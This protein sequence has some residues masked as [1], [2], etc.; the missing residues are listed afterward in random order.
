M[1]EKIAASCMILVSLIAG[2]VLIDS[3]FLHPINSA[4]SRPKLNGKHLDIAG[5]DWQK[6]QEHLVIAL[7]S[8]CRFCIADAPLYRQVT[9]D[10]LSNKLNIVVISSDD[11]D[12]LHRFLQQ[13]SIHADKILL[14]PLSS[15]GVTST[16]T[17][18]IVDSQGIVR[19]TFIGQLDQ[20]RQT[21]LRERLHLVGTQAN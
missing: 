9:N 8:H 20:S 17:L 16:P 1:L 3:H 10:S 19:A 7:S 5:I 21:A 14:Q 15:I 12:S 13:N 18:L 4:I 2:Y 11:S 6:N